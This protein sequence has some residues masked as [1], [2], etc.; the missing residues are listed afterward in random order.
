MMRKTVLSAAVHS[1]AFL[2]LMAAGASAESGPTFRDTKSQSLG[3]TGVASS[4]GATALFLNP[5][6]LGR[7]DGGGMG[8]SLDLGL[9]SVL[10]D[11]AS[12]A[13]DN[14]KY[15]NHTDTLLTKMGPVDNKWA[16]FSQSLM[17]YGN[18]EGV[19]FSVLSDTRYDLT[20]AKAVVTPVLGVGALSDLVLTAGKGFQVED[21]YRFG[22]ALKYLYR[23]R[24]TD[25]LIGTTNNEFF[26]VKHAWEKPDHG[27]SDKLAK[28]G[29]AGDIAQT[30]QGVGL[31][32][33]AEK[34]I[35][36]DWTAGLSLLDFP[37]VIDQ[38]FVK[39]DINL[40]L[41]Y[42]KPVDWVPDLDN[43][44]LVNLDWQHFL[45]PGTPWFKQLKAGVALE[46]Y[47]NKRPVSYI[48]VGLNDGYPTFGI[49]LGYIV[50]LSYVYVAEETGTY[51]G[52]E[53]LSFHK[54]VLQAE[55]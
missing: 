22:F 9:N 44:V 18:W 48:A 7:E 10:L 47:M 36:K 50:Y 2:S 38:S 21:G 20:L 4:K 43:K 8:L 55:F 49:R 37:T 46:G 40:G 45:I 32:L 34:D 25:R 19:G 24:F 30:S 53:K 1:A 33:G 11:Y 35:D 12:W 6:A 16:P 29:V 27:W 42:H 26:I 13:A 52:Q 14:Y 51:P 54:L 5:A 31:N 3:R 15:L 17:L 28:L 39:P 23:L 41:A